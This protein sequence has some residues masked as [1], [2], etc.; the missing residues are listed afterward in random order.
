MPKIKVP[1]KPSICDNKLSFHDCELAILRQSVDENEQI[2]NKNIVSNAQ[3]KDILKIVEDFIIHKK[4][5]CYGGTAIN[6]ILPI[7]AQFYNR[8][9]ELPDY[10][11][12]SSNALNDAKELA[13]IYYKAG[14]EDVEAKSGVHKG[15]F[16]VFVNYIPIAD[17]TEM[18]DSLFKTIQTES[19]IKAGIRYAPVNYLR[20]SMYLELSRPEGDIS[21]WEKV[22]KRLTLLNKFYPLKSQNCDKIDFQRNIET[23]NNIDKTSTVLYDIIRN[24]FIDQGVVFFG[25]HAVSSY[26]KYMSKHKKHLLRKVPDFDVL[27]DDIER[28]SLILSEELKQAGYQDVITED[29]EKIG[30]LIPRKIKVSLGKEVVA[31]IYEPIACHSYNTIKVHN[32]QINIAT[33]DTILTFYLSFLYT[34]LNEYH[35]DRLLCMAQFLYD[36]E[37]K[38]RLNQKGLLKRFTM[39]CIGKQP[40]IEDMRAE[41]AVKFKELKNN[42]NCNEFERLFLRYIPSNEADKNNYQN[43]LKKNKKT[44]NLNSKKTMKNKR[45]KK[46]KAKNKSVKTDILTRIQTLLT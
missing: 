38:N 10:D 9:V 43:E 21:R 35:S 39:K 11:F 34:K 33:I 42:R 32:S 3:V 37:E 20:M 2:R 19:I 24:S 26:S 1:K 31:Y 8:D 6:N 40:T 23:I 30:E 44:D 4:L 7:H 17:I 22:L 12:F 28:T 45:N 41:K 5:V 27:S 15:T 46:A 29:I 36:V 18:V 25:G 16:K 14:Y 13:D